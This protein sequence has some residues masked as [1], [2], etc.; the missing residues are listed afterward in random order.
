MGLI[1]VIL[2]AVLVMLVSGTVVTGVRLA[3]ALRQLGSVVDS[4]QRSIRPTVTELT[5]AGQTASAEMAGL[6]AS[7]EDL[8]AGR[9]APEGRRAVPDR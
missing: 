4:A 9:R 7:I 2:V 1:V 3:T 8:T 5:E 6:R